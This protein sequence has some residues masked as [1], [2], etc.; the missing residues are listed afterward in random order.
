MNQTE[1]RAV[2]HVPEYT[3]PGQLLI[4]WDKEG[5]KIE[6]KIG[7]FWTKVNSLRVYTDL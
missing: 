3:Y 7:V 6:T 2:E 4:F 5:R 1:G